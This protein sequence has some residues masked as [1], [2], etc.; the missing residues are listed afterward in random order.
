MA[1]LVLGNDPDELVVNYVVGDPF[2][3]GLVCRD[4][5]GAAIAWPGVPVL[6]FPELPSDTPDV[7]LEWVATLS[8]Y[9]TVSDALATWDKLESEV[10]AL[11]EDSTPVRLAIGGVTIW[12]GVTLPNA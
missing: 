9:E 3:V 10:D 4:A 5:T 2:N 7:S 8:A 12:K 11:G 6:E 1:K